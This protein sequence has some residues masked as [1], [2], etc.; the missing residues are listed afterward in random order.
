MAL[1]ENNERTPGIVSFYRKLDRVSRSEVHQGD[2]QVVI[3]KL[4]RDV[5]DVAKVFVLVR[6]AKG[7]SAQ[8]RWADISQ[9]GSTS[10][11]STSTSH[12]NLPLLIPENV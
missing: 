3:E 9:V 4:L 2:L 12:E 10:T 1:S 8:Q 6:A 7:K 11:G 5:P